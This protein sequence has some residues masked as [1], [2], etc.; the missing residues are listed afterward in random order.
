MTQVVAKDMGSGNVTYPQGQLTLR[1]GKTNNNYL[2]QLFNINEDNV[3]IPFDL[4]GPYSY[5]LVMPTNESGRTIT[6]RQTQDSSKQQLGIGTL[7]FYITAENARSV[8]DVPETNRY[9]AIMTD[10][11]GIAA[12]ETTL[13]EGKVA[14]LS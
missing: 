13:Y 12:Q 10:N 5:K 9:F 11:S 14:W 6:I 8:M 3:R 1:L 4:T 2:I 7:M